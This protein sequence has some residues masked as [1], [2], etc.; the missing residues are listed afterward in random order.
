MRLKESVSTLVLQ[1]QNLREILGNIIELTAFPHSV[2]QI[3]MLLSK[4]RL[5]LIEHI[6]LENDVFYKDYLNEKINFSTLIEA[7]KFIRQMNAIEKSITEFLD[8]YQTEAQIHD[9]LESF[10]AEVKIIAEKLSARIE[11]EEKG[12]YEIYRSPR[13]D[14][15]ITLAGKKSM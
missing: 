2:L 7:Y 12:I 14:V 15:E 5:H 1:H 6:K 11:A 10:T 8:R 4:F 3:E 9:S 13:R